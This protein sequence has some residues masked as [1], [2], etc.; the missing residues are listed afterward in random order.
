DEPPLENFYP[1][2]PPWAQGD[3]QRGVSQENY[4]H[5]SLSLGLGR[6]HREYEVYQCHFKE[7]TSLRAP[8]T[9][10]AKYIRTNTTNTCL[11]YIGGMWE[12]INDFQPPATTTNWVASGHQTSNQICLMP[13][14]EPRLSDS[15]RRSEGAAK[16]VEYWLWP[17]IEAWA[18]AVAPSPTLGR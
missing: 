7:L 4:N 5:Q 3:C 15:V 1:Q 8:C 2:N 13:G 12:E 16:W 18:N 10:G 14:R 9:Q 11:I 6:G 17:N